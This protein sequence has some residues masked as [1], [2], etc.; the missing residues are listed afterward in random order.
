MILMSS[1][2]GVFF[3][4]LFMILEMMALGCGPASMAPATATSPV[5]GLIVNV[6]EFDASRA[7]VK[8]YSEPVQPYGL[9]TAEAIVEAL[10]EAGIAAQIARPGAPPNGHVIVEGSVTMVE[11]GSTTSRV[12]LGGFGPVGA[13]RF[14]VAGSV[15]RDGM[16]LGEFAVDRLAWMDVWWPSAD[17]LLSR[18]AKVIGFDIANMI[19]TGRYSR[20]SSAPASTRNTAERL[21]EL[22]T[23]LEKGLVTREEYEQKRAV[24]LKQL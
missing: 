17:R 16:L 10:Q 3:W 4:S 21:Q 11:G 23:L 2:R 22:E 12:L 8:D 24:I 15:R 9:Q 14:G 19:S 5:K 7:D 18:T 13:T 1:S 6:R 20:G